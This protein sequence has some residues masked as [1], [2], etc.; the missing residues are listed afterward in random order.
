[1]SLYPENRPG[2]SYTGKWHADVRASKH[3]ERPDIEAASREIL[4]ATMKLC[5]AVRAD[6]KANVAAR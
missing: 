1:M 3:H 5:T 6:T 2:S 4:S